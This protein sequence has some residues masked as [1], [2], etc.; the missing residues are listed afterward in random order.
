MEER[1]EGD[2]RGGGEEGGKER[3][4]DGKREKKQGRL[5]REFTSN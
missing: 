1:G 5:I 4:G 2:G 3:R